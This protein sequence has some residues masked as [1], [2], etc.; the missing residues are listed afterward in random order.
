MFAGLFTYAIMKAAQARRLAS[1]FEPDKLIGAPGRAE[2]SLDPDGRVRALGESWSATAEDP[3]I[4]EGEA[5]RI[6][7]LDGI[8]LVVKRKINFED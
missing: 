5:I 8:R 1:E 7:R 6:V 4:K 3:P 2:T